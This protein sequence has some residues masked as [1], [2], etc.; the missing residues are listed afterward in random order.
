[1]VDPGGCCWG[2]FSA[3]YPLGGGGGAVVRPSRTNPL[4]QMMGLPRPKPMILKPVLVLS[5]VVSA[6]TV[7]LCL[8]LYNVGP[9][10]KTL[11]QHCRDAKC[12]TNILCLLGLPY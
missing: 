8:L 3:L 7:P 2:K 12:Y 10:L 6:A 1:M 11:S 5:C 4:R 9:T